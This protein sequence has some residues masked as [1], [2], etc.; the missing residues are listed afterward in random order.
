MLLNLPLTIILWV[1]L[2]IDFKILSKAI[3]TRIEAFEKEIEDYRFRRRIR[4]RESKGF[5][6]TIALIL[7]FFGFYHGC[8]VMIL[9]IQ[10]FIVWALILRGIPHLGFRCIASAIRRGIYIKRLLAI[11]VLVILV[12]AFLAFPFIGRVVSY[13]RAVAMRGI[14][15]EFKEASIEMFPEISPEELRVNTAEIAWSIANIRKTSA[16]SW[17]TSVHLGM[18]EGELCW[19]C[20]ISEP[21]MFGTWLVGGSNKIKEMI[22]IPVN[23]A[24]GER[25]K[26]IPFKSEFGEGLWFGKSILV[27]ASDRNPTRM[28]TRGYITADETGKLVYVTTSYVPIPFG[29]YVNPKVQVWD[30]N[31]RLLAEYKPEE[32]PDWIVQRWDERFVEVMGNS[33]GDFRWNAEN[34]LNFWNGIPYYSDR[35]ADPAEPGGLRYQMWYG[36]LVAVYLFHNKRNPSILEFIIL[37]K[38]DGIYLYSAHHLNLISPTEAKAV[39]KAGLP[40]LAGEGEYRTPLA[41][42]YRIGSELYYHIPVYAYANGRYTPIYFALVRATDRWC[43]RI[44]CAEEGG[45]LNAVKEAYKQIGK[46]VTVERIVSGILIDKDE[47]VESGNT[48]WI[49][50]LKIE[51]GTILNV[52]AKAEDLSWEEINFIADL[53]IGDSIT[54]VVNENNIVVKVV[55]E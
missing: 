35:S 7:F 50:T 23:D 53:E 3:K 18:Y 40:P 29:L 15:K 21:P 39:A 27:H 11:I 32:A 10:S 46:A 37:A 25:A 44:S 16:A 54:I 1:S 41:L 5:W 33:F 19:I 38:K 47:Y 13:T 26:V 34:E 42:L 31:G 55:G 51:D 45:M 12:L 22:I 24:T 8:R 30:P 28:F 4:I 9:P 48:R 43:L 49:L 14:F 52:L 20:T 17:V 6:I 2:V 36:E